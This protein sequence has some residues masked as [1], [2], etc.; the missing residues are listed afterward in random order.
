MNLEP[1]DNAEL[2][3]LAFYGKATEIVPR[4]VERF[5]ADGLGAFAARRQ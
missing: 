1:A 2:F 5:L 4:F 3:D